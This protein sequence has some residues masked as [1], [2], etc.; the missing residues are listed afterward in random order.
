M[1]EVTIN[2]D[3]DE[4]DKAADF[5]CRAFQLQV[6]R[7]FGP[8]A[9][10]LN[11]ASS[12][13]YLLHKEKGSAPVRKLDDKRDYDR[14]WTPVHVDFIVDQ[15]EPA[16]ERALAAGAKQES[17]LRQYDW[18]R[19]VVLADPWGHGFCL[20]QFVNRGYDEIADKLQK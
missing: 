4:L 11:G 3:V 9:V 12:R 18:G 6:G 17:S 16:L 7:R 10:E 14:H 2:I 20:L 5:Y 13:I 8:H 19:I 15:L 1:T